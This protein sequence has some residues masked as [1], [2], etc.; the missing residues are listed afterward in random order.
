MPTV[1]KIWLKLPVSLHDCHIRD[2]K[3]PVFEIMA[4]QTRGKI[5][6]RD[7]NNVHVTNTRKIRQ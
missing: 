1:G 3:T 5:V 2:D 4:L 7:D 6:Q